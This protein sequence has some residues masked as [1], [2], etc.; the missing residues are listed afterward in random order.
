MLKKRII[1]KLL[2]S[3]N[4]G[5]MQILVVTK[6]FNKRIPIGNP[7]SQAKIYESQLADELILINLGDDKSKDG[8]LKT[9]SNISEE[10]A[11]PLTIGGS[12]NNIDYVKSLFG[13]G[14]DKVLVNSYAYR[15]PELMNTISEMYGSQALV[16]GV[17]VK[18][19]KSGFELYSN[20]GTHRENRSLLEWITDIEKRGAGEIALTSIDYDGTGKGIDIEL[21]TYVRSFCKL[22]L[23]IT[24]GCGVASHF[25]E[26]F[27]NGADAVAAGTFFCRRDQNPLQ[28]RSHVK[29]AGINIRTKL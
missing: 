13:N 3:Q 29:N 27:I 16:V 22:P 5:G 1:P 12:I 6:Q 2:I 8:F 25:T 28:C 4:V 15:N 9:I 21:L 26:G 17:D 11:T 7:I 20:H 19:G 14:A 23:I 24:G 10:L 18:R